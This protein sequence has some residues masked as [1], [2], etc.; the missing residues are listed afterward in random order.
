MLT[1]VILTVEAAFHA[2]GFT[3]L[4]FN[5]RG[6][7]ASEGTH[8]EGRTE[9]ADVAGALAHLRASLDGSPRLVAVAGYSFGSHVGGRAAAADPGVGFYLGVAPVVARYD[10]GFL[11]GLRGRVALISGAA[12]RVLRPGE[13]RGAGGEPARA[14]LAPRARGG[15]LLRGLAGRARRRVPG[16]H[17]LGVGLIDCA[18][19]LGG[20]IKDYPPSIECDTEIGPTPGSQAPT[21]RDSALKTVRGAHERV[22]L[23]QGIGGTIDCIHL[24]T[25]RGRRWHSRC[26]SERVAVVGRDA[27]EGGGCTD[28]SGRRRA[29]PSRSRGKEQSDRAVGPHGACLTWGSAHSRS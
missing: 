17:H 15:P 8:G 13:A 14:A 10:Y 19:T 29:P 1:P 24:E 23:G 18:A 9:V 28:P 21:R 25:Q 7:G 11:A 5:F 20:R 12:R 26:T 2:A 4:A 16:R 6:V 22:Q 27:L 3:T